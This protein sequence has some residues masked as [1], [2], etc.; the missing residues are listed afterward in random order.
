MLEIVIPLFKVNWITKAVLESLN[1]HYNPRKIH[2]IS[3]KNEIE[4]IEKLDL[5][6]S[7]EC[8]N[9]DNFFFKKI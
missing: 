7:I 9:E 1:L 3:V 2:I 8:H 4:I 6:L 5:D